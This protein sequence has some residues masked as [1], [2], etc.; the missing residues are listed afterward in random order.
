MS[1]EDDYMSEAFLEQCAQADVKPGLGRSVKGA[2]DLQKMKKRVALEEEQRRNKKIRKTS[3]QVEVEKRD[4]GLSKTLDSSNKGFAMLAKMGYQPGNSLG[5]DN[6][7]RLEPVGI[8]VKLGRGGLGREAVL[9]DLEIKKERFL[10]EK[11][12]LREERAL[13]AAR[14]FD[15][16]AF[17]AQMRSKH[18][19]KRIESDL[20]KSQKACQ[21]L[22]TTKGID[23][24]ADTWFWPPKPKV[25]K[26]KSDDEDNE[27][28]VEEEE[29]DEEAVNE[30]TSEEM[31]EMIIDYL[32]AEHNYC[33]F[34]GI[35]FT[36]P[37]DRDANCP[38]P[39][40]DDH[41]D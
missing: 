16:H 37:E 6:T 32:R 26:L 25:K 9:K 17:R 39:T 12:R 23:E 34:C 40:R 20:Y 10:E 2:R 21:D 5:K 15:P 38:G 41:D 7:G 8:Q 14:D 29:E 4:E 30:F 28:D 11:Q 1:D 27:E 13:Q 24:P 31:L 33:L 36:D 22:D 18:L 35:G 3:K 19:A